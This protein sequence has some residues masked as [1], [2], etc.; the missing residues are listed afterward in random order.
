MKL[1]GG[2]KGASEIVQGGGKRVSEIIQWGVYE[3]VRK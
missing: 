1:L 3:I 2:R